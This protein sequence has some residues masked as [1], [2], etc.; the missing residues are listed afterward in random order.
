MMAMC[1]GLLFKEDMMRSLYGLDGDTLLSSDELEEV[2][3]HSSVIDG[4]GLV[5]A[6][7]NSYMRDGSAGKF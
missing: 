3:A 6:G 1:W 4:D 5:A 7:A 2:F